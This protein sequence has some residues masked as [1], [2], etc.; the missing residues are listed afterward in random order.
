MYQSVQLYCKLF[1]VNFPVCIQTPDWHTSL[2]AEKRSDCFHCKTCVQK[3]FYKQCL[4]AQQSLLSVSPQHNFGA[5]THGWKSTNCPGR[6]WS[7]V[8]LMRVLVVH[9][10][11]NWPCF[12]FISTTSLT[13]W[14]KKIRNL[15]QQL[16]LEKDTNQP[17]RNRQEGHRKMK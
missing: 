1:R 4:Y 7:V 15:G 11:K 13:L 6:V 16:P 17:I 8:K 2:H 14:C 10:I 5:T 9:T 12:I 3:M